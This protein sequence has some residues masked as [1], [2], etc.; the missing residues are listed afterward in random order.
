MGWISVA[1]RGLN[2]EG[3][4]WVLQLVVPWAGDL[5]IAMKHRVEPD[6]WRELAEGV[7]GE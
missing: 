6:C 5:P 3:G 7:R 4:R 1:R 2:Y